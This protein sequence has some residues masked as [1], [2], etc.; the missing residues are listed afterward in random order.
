VTQSWP[1]GEGL[2]TTVNQALVNDAIRSLLVFQVLL[3]AIMLYAVIRLPPFT[4]STTSDENRPASARPTAVH[5][6][7]SRPMPVPTTAWPQGGLAGSM[8]APFP[9]IGI[10]SQAGH[11]DITAQSDRDWSGKA[12]YVARHV[13]TP[14]PHTILRPKVSGSP[15][16]GPAPKPPGYLP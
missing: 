13:A 12:R 8:Y 15:P 1:S 10:A 16:W 2:V 3:L 6:P 14:E 11:A 7:P 9:Q 4:P 5:I